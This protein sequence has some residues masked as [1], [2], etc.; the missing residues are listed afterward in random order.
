MIAL[1]AATDDETHDGTIAALPPMPQLSR[2]LKPKSVLAVL[3]H[4]LFEA[5]AV[6]SFSCGPLAG[7]YAEIVELEKTLP[8]MHT[9]PDD[10]Y[11][12]PPIQMKKKNGQP[13]TAGETNTP[14]STMLPH[15][16]GPEPENRLSQFQL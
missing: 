5:C 6:W 10:L 14:D 3:S 15:G 4:V 11:V 16:G 7:L 12:K 1:G 13:V 9:L 2:T 8:S